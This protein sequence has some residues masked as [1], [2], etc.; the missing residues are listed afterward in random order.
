MPAPKGHARYGGRKKGQP[1]KDRFNLAERA[2]E[3]GVD[4]FEILLRFAA[5]DWK[6]LGY[7]FAEDPQSGKHTIDP[8]VRSKAASEAC[9]YLY[10]K[11]KSIEH[12][13]E[14]GLPDHVK[15]AADWVAGATQEELEAFV[16]KNK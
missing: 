9:Q 13:G 2:K 15:T 1:N 3:L 12:S 16:K 11:K 8:S 4:P 7:A 14:I 5:G 10:P 6:S